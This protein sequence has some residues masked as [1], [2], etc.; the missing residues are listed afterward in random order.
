MNQAFIINLANK[1]ASENFMDF[2]E[3]EDGEI[4]DIETALTVIVQSAVGSETDFEED[5]MF[6]FFSN[7]IFPES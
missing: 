2:P 3:Y 6:D 4:V 1:V 5:K 7:S